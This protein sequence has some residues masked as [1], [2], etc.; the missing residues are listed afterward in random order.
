MPRKRPQVLG[1]D[2]NRSERWFSFIYKRFYSAG[3][4]VFSVFTNSRRAERIDS[5]GALT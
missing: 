5:A 1:G 4:R 2:L 3:F